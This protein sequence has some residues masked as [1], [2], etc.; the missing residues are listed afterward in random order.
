MRKEIQ[1]SKTLA[2]EFIWHHRNIIVLRSPSICLHFQLLNWK[3]SYCSSSRV[4]CSL[5]C[6]SATDRN[7]LSSLSANSSTTCLP[8]E[9]MDKMLHRQ[10]PLHSW[11]RTQG[12]QSSD[13]SH[14]ISEQFSHFWFTKRKIE[15]FSLRMSILARNNA[16]KMFWSWLRSTAWQLSVPCISSSIPIAGLDTQSLNTYPSSTVFWSIFP[17]PLHFQLTQIRQVRSPI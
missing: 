4:D 5:S 3:Y 17:L 9:W 11:M 13:K 12:M 15:L 14:D 6:S 8:Y 16:H 1:D 7:N 2:I 10:A